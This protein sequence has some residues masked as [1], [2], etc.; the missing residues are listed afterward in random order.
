[1]ESLAG[2]PNP[3]SD[4]FVRDAWDPATS[5]VAVIHA[6]AFDCCC[7]ALRT[8]RSGAR[9]AS[10]LLHGQPGSGKTHLLSRFRS[11]VLGAAPPRQG[12]AP[13][14]VVFTSTRMQTTPRM[15]WRHVRR[16][17]ADDL[18][19]PVAGGGTQL[20]E[21]LLGRLARIRGA[22]GDLRLWWEWLKEEHAGPGQFR[23]LLDDLF[24]AL[25][26]DAGLGRNLCQ[27][28]GH[29]LLGRHRR[30]A[31]AWLRGEP[32]PEEALATLGV[33]TSPE[34]EEQQ[35][36]GAL[37][38]ILALCRLV[39]PGVPVVFCF[40]QVEALQ[41]DSQDQEG[42]FTFGQMI[43]GLHDQTNNTLLISCVQSSILDRFRDAV[44]TAD[45]DRLAQVQNSLD[46]LTWEQAAQLLAAR[47]DHHPEL[48]PLRT[49]RPGQA[50]WPLRPA[51]LQ[52]RLDTT[53]PFPARKV[54]SVAAALFEGFSPPPPLNEFL[55]QTWE[56]RLQGARG[57][58]SAEQ[59]DEIIGHGLPL[60]VDL[61]A[62]EWQ[63]VPGPSLR[64]VDLAFQNVDG[65]VGVSLCNHRHLNGLVHRLK[66]LQGQLKQKKLHKLVLLRDPR[67]PV[68]AHAVKTRKLL[69]ELTGQEARFL[70][71][72]V[73]ALAA[74]EALR[75]LL[76]DAKAGDL[77]HGG[78]TI[79]P[80][81]V[82]EWLAAHLPP[83]LHELLEDVL[84]YPGITEP[85]PEDVRLF[86]DLTEL[87][88]QRY[89]LPLDEAAAVL[90]RPPAD[91]E[92]C[93]RQ[94]PQQF[95]LLGGPP[96]VLFHLSVAQ[97]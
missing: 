67:L 22:Q 40:D 43:A 54:L 3:F 44:R 30:D 82:Q 55:D 47:M 39:G 73:E 6:R 95:G 49:S 77:A 35:E 50:L 89:L 23:R 94:H 75:A 46:L 93:A 19:R 88:G 36:D 11:H 16:S 90:E 97:G 92:A 1:V 25:D 21:L 34:E 9:S 59:T 38:T 96:P 87:L 27:V 83:A 18:V 62:K 31:R 58:V 51:D 32:L 66:R 74:L 85:E 60:L 14:E 63:T 80:E 61:A 86:D 2:L 7:A 84:S 68:G 78:D 29:L 53:K 4:P 17:F 79:S 65:R 81:T 28:L 15:V 37:Q 41:R 76:S 57:T 13:T 26:Q 72:S 45:W 56:Q 70:R 24:D 33:S 8:V 69:D 5:D 20:E 64:D 12:P 91:L 42:F 71:P 48:K 52:A 10:V